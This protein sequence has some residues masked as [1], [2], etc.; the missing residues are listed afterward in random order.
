MVLGP[1][2]NIAIAMTLDPKFVD[3]VGRFYIMGASVHGMGNVAPSIEYN[4]YQD[5][6]SNFIVLNKTRR[7]PNILL[8]WETIYDAGI[9]MV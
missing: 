7:L 5:P 8:P 9:P 3:N 2:T 1:L 6:L 4:F